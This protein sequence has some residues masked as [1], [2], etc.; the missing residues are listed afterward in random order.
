MMASDVLTVSAA[1]REIAARILAGA[2]Q[3]PPVPRWYRAVTASMLPAHLREAFGLPYGK[4]EQR[5]AA[6]ALGFVRRVYPLLP[7]RLRYAAPYQ[8]AVARLS[9][10]DRPDALTR[11]LN[12]LWMGRSSMGG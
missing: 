10:R 7:S 9:G 1:G 2:G 8:E 4:A 6:R 5:A 12:R 11:W 3:V